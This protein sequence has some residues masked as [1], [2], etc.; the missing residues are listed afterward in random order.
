MNYE[1]KKSI[2]G[3]WAIMNERIRLVF[4]FF[5]V[6]LC[7]SFVQLCDTAFFRIINDGV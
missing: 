6:Q 1:L 7:V 3:H 5:S 4:L 2:T